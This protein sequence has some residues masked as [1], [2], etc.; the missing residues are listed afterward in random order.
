MVRNYK[1]KTNRSQYD[2]E[3]LQHA[4]EAAQSGISGRDAAEAYEV[5]YGSVA[6]RLAGYENSKFQSDRT[7]NLTM[8]EEEDLVSYLLI[9]GKMGEGYTKQEVCQ[10]VGEYVTDKGLSVFFRCS[11]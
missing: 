7:T 3:D 10:L 4:V 11:C 6:R 9:C 8:I 2:P 1:R 5:P